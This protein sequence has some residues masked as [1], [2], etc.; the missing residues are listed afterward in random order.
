M[1]NKEI[2]KMAIFMIIL[3]IF[4]FCNI[5]SIFWRLIYEKGFNVSGIGT[6]WG[7]GICPAVADGGGG[8]V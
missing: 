3:Y 2:H 7:I 5:L 8:S 4:I 6:N 1:G